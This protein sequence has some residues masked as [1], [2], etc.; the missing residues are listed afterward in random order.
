MTGCTG[1]KTIFVVSDSIDV[2]NKN[3]LSLL[4]G[5]LQ[6]VSKI[7]SVISLVAGHSYVRQ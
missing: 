4:A 6:K 5:E 2:E 1:V 7:L 3:I